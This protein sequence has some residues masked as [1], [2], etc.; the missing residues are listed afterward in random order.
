MA[1]SYEDIFE[2]FKDNITD[3]DL[4]LFSQDMQNDMLTSLL[5]KA[6]SKCNGVCKENDID[7]S[8]KDDEIQQFEM[9]IPSDIIDI[10]I[11]WMTVLWLKPYLNNTENLRNALNTKDFSFCSPANLLEKISNT[12]ELARKHAKSLTNE[13]SFAYADMSELKT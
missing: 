1:T 7:L 5:N 8:K 9:D 12:Y 10:V 11:E 2:S 4:L 3:P 13:Y 6:I